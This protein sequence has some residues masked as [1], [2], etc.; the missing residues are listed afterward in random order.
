MC[1]FEPGM[2]VSLRVGRVEWGPPV[3]PESSAVF[4]AEVQGA[5]LIRVTTKPRCLAMVEMLTE[6]P[7]LPNLLLSPMQ[8]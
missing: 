2:F 1:S 3:L 8:K 7:S 4:S 5:K 6:L